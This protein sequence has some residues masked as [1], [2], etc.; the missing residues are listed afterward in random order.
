MAI[1]EKCPFCGE[2]GEIELYCN[3]LLFLKRYYVECE[4]CEAR[5]PVENSEERAL[6][7]WNNTTKR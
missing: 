7:S 5:G 2:K 4:N 6:I 1:V 3:N